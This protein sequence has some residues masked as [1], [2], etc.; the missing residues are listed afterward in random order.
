MRFIKSEIIVYFGV[1]FGGVLSGLN[2]GILS[3]AFHAIHTDFNS[4]AF[5]EGLLTSAIFFAVIPTCLVTGKLNDIFGRKK[6][7]I[8]SSLIFITGGITFIFIDTY[9]GIFITRVYIGIGIGI[10]SVTIPAYLAEIT[11]FVNRN[12]VMGLYQF[13]ISFGL[14][15]G[16]CIDYFLIPLE[17]NKDLWPSNWQLML[18]FTVLAAAV[19]LL[20]LII[21]PESPL[22]T[23]KKGEINKA[24]KVLTVLYRKHLDQIDSSL[25][26]FSN[27]EKSSP[28]L[29]EIFSKENKSLFPSICLAAFQQFIGVNVVFYYGSTL[30]IEVNPDSAQVIGSIKFLQEDELIAICFGIFSII[31]GV[32]SLYLLGKVKNKGLLL[33]GVLF[34]GLFSVFVSILGFLGRLHVLGVVGI[35]LIILYVIVFSFTWGPLT[36]NI[37]SQIS[38]SRFR[39]INVSIATTFNWISNIIVVTF[40]PI[41]AS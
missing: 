12:R 17:K 39:N 16:Y 37:I 23:Y 26:L 29:R 34:M 41:L 36:W 32:F 9:L 28:K 38:P 30:A 21:V 6:L 24:K 10:V 22:F 8:I 2:C 19:M 11:L 33:F 13:F 5:E 1:A 4:N 27:V 20:L 18:S 7:L 40:F 35:I 31:G 14:L 3:G 25:E 15:I